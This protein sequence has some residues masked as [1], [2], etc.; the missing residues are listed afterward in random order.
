PPQHSSMFLS[1]CL[2]FIDHP[3]RASVCLTSAASSC[4]S[5][6]RRK[7]QGPRRACIS[8]FVS[9]VLSG[10]VVVHFNLLFCNDRAQMR[11]G[12]NEELL[13]SLS[14]KL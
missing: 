3:S 2:L 14:E 11:R 9:P 7:S 12:C 5:E 6:G 10:A 13:N 4:S 8:E 1:I